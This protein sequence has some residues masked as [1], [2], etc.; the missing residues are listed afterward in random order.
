MVKKFFKKISTHVFR[1]LTKGHIIYCK[2]E[3]LQRESENI[4]LRVSESSQ[5]I[6]KSG[7]EKRLRLSEAVFRKS[8]EK[9]QKSEDGS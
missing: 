5:E 1:V 2:R 8:F 7:A 9:G 6:L 4:V 3:S